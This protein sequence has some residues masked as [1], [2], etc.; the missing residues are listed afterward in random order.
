M[1]IDIKAKEVKPIRQTYSHLAR[2]FGEDRPATR[3][4]EGVMDIQAVN[5]FHYR[6]TWQTDKEL[7][8]PS[9][10]AIVMEDF[11]RFLDPRQ[12]YYGT[13]TMARAKQQASADQNFKFVEKRGL[14]SLIPEETSTK[15]LSH[16]TPLRHYEWGANMNNYQI[17]AMG[18]GA[19]ITSAAAM[20][21]SDRLG[22]AQYITRI[23]LA[24]T[25]NDTS[26]L[27]EAKET[28]LSAEAAQGLRKV[29]ED[30]FVVEDWFELF[31]AQNLAMDGLVHPLFFVKLE[32][33][34]NAAGA[35]TYTML[36]EFIVDWYAESSRWVDK[37]IEVA[38]SESAAN[39]ALVQ[40][41]FDHWSAATAEA[42]APIANV[43]LSDG[44]AAMADLTASLKARAAKL[45]LSA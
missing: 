23:A 36:T 21:G 14:L 33:E 5:N 6:P 25:D 28:W 27:D 12:Y 44:D 24:L 30:S 18:Y 35:A 39:A 7:Y 31:V 3:Y 4:Q 26:V 11:H 42:L 8:D 9:R 43:L 20:H 34:L 45:G 2:R 19:P 41:W 1:Q 32:A 10:T 37:Q 15:I 38:V 29:V 16:V 13:Y 17:C 40:G 22:N